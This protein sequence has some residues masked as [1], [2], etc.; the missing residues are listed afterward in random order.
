MSERSHFLLPH[1]DVS[2]EARGE[3]FALGNQTI[4]IEVN[5]PR[6]VTTLASPQGKGRGI[7]LPVNLSQEA[8]VNTVVRDVPRAIMLLLTEIFE[9]LGDEDIKFLALDLKSGKSLEA[10]YAAIKTNPNNGTHDESETSTDVPL[11]LTLQPSNLINDF[12]DVS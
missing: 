9:S 7:K 11:N 3:V 8:T 2:I 5:D 10:K 4:S 6:E 12:K 1:V